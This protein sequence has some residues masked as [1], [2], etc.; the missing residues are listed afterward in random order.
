[1]AGLVDNFEIVLRDHTIGDPMREDVQ[2]TNLTLAEIPSHL[3][4]YGTP[5]SVTVVRQ[6]LKR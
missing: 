1:M 4:Q 3:V 6:L 5:V 2:W